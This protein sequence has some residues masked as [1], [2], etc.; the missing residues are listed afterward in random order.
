MH[1]TYL[2]PPAHLIPRCRDAPPPKKSCLVNVDEDLE[3]LPSD[4]PFVRKPVH[5]ADDVDLVQVRVIT[6]RHL[7]PRC[8]RENTPLLGRVAEDNQKLK[9]P[10]HRGPKARSARPHVRC[11]GRFGAAYATE[12]SYP[13][14][15][16]SSDGSQ[17]TPGADCFIGATISFRGQPPVTAECGPLPVI[18][19][20]LTIEHAIDGSHA[21]AFDMS[22]LSSAL[23]AR[24]TLD[25]SALQHALPDLEAPGTAFQMAALVEALPN[26]DGSCSSG[27]SPLSPVPKSLAAPFTSH[28]PEAGHSRVVVQT[29]VQ[30]GPMVRAW[31]SHLS[32]V[33]FVLAFIFPR[34]APAMPAVYAF[35][36]IAAACT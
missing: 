33:L 20:G 18:L 2:P 14:F 17:A 10:K 4:E 3:E 29:R 12:P 23:P 31:S 30:V 13:R 8:W 1:F 19:Q 28:S 26:L 5:F 36:L 6:A 11:P 21:P 34:L 35:I 9:S 15:E 25:M 22:K 24:H 32:W 27:T 16:P 7:P